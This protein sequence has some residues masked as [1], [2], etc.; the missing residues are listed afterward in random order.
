MENYSQIGLAWLIWTLQT[1]VM[2][3]RRAESQIGKFDFWPLKIGSLLDFCVCRW[4][5]T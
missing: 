2:A 1:Q 5:V 4:H 3:K